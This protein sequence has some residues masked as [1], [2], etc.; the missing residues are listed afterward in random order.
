MFRVFYYVLLLWCTWY[1][2]EYLRL[3][4]NHQ[5]I[6][7]YHFTLELLFWVY[8]FYTVVLFFSTCKK[9]IRLYLNN[10]KVI[11]FLLYAQLK[12][13]NVLWQN[14]YLCFK[15]LQTSLCKSKWI[16]FSFFIIKCLL[17][18]MFTPIIIMTWLNYCKMFWWLYYVDTKNIVFAW[19]HYLVCM[20]YF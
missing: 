19:F 16:A 7:T 20:N 12:V 9:W 2:I 6:Q 13:H 4:K 5:I 10:D 8:C 14:K 15:L 3:N 17:S 18:S 1:N 11:S